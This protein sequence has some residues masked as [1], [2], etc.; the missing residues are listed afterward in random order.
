M[1]RVLG[2]SLTAMTYNSKDI[3]ADCKSMDFPQDSDTE[4]TTCFADGGYHTFAG[5]L[6]GG[7]DISLD[8]YYNNQASTSEG[9]L[10][11]TANL[12][13]SAVFSWSD[14]TR[15]VTVNAIVTKIPTKWTP[16]ALGMNT[17]S[18]KQTGAITNA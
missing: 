16:G 14:G 1:G 11:W 8:M 7:G 6:K 10:F 2:S 12:G 18:L 15:T 4:D 3:R 5:T 13:T 17:I 9:Y